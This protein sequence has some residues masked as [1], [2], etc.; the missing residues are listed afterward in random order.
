[1]LWKK[2]KNLYFYYTTYKVEHDAYGSLHF[3]HPEGAVVSQRT[4]PRDH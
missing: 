1:M 4:A 2:K 3:T